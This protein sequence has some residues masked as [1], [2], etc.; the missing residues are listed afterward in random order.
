MFICSLGVTI[1]R[2][3]MSSEGTPVGHLSQ[4]LDAILRERGLTERQAAER[5]DM[6][7]ESFRKILRGMTA[8]PRDGT[9]RRIADGFGVPVANLMEARARDANEDFASA[10]AVQD[11]TTTAALDIAIARVGDLR[12]EELDTVRAQMEELLR[13]MQ[14]EHDQGA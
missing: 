1:S 11:I 10:A 13:A 12:P 3:T 14:A 8:R 7:F 4:L 2:L 9:L 5:V 6:P